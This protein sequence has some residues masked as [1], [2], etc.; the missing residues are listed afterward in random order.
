MTLVSEY[1]KISITKQT[2]LQ[3]PQ[4]DNSFAVSYILLSFCL[5]CVMFPS[6]C[7]PCA[8]MDSGSLGDVL[9]EKETDMCE[10]PKR[11]VAKFKIVELFQRCRSE[12]EKVL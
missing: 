1:D 9:N 6:V 7:L 2:N 8:S 12:L 11:Y 4:D 10:N 5:V 3:I